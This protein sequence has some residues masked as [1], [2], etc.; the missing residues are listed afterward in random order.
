MDVLK[1]LFI[2]ISAF[3]I[4]LLVTLN[5]VKAE[6]TLL[7]TGEK[8][9]ALTQKSVVLSEPRYN[10]DLYEFFSNTEKGFIIPGLYEGLIP[11]GIFYD[12]AHEVFLISG[13]YKGKSLPSQIAVIDK[14]G[15]LIKSVGIT[16]ENGK[17]SVGHFGGIAAFKDNIY[18]A[19]TKYF[20]VVSFDA[21]MDAES[22]SYVP[23]EAK[24][25]TG[26]ICSNVN[27]CDGTLYICEFRQKEADNPQ[28]FAY[29]LDEN[30]LYGIKKDKL[31]S[32]NKVSYDYSFSIPLRVQGMVKLSDGRIVFT[33]SHGT[34]YSTAYIYRNIESEAKAETYYQLKNEDLS[35]AYQVPSYVQEITIGPDKKAYVLTE[36]AADSYKNKEG[37]MPIDFVMKWNIPKKHL[38]TDICA[39]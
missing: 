16:D 7:E 30:G 28:C 25:N 37:N 21:V 31:D 1:R 18:I 6:P 17:K 12:N 10:F 4:A 38:Y 26:T 35:E 22:G 8:S 39:L 15:K 32:K 2:K 29:E 3:T 24:L 14:N 23:A 34:D 27:V 20:Y 5:I 13:Y 36:S 9:T 19:S 33:S 11:Q